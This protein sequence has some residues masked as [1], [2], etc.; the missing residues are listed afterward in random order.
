M[1]IR[2]SA[3]QVCGIIDTILTE[4]EIQPFIRTASLLVDEHLADYLPVITTDL[5]AEIETYLAA[6]FVTLW[7]PRTSEETAGNTSFK[8]EGSANGPGLE[9]SKYGQMAKLLD[10][11][12]RLSQLSNPNRI[13]FLGR[14]ANEITTAT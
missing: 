10:P 4:Q 7:D 9:S 5:L 1:A 6:H 12:G 13:S 11:S 3:P 8:Y 14:A 2:T